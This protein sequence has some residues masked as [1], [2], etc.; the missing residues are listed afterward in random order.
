MKNEFL[1]TI[2]QGLLKGTEEEGVKTFY[3]IPYGT[4]SGHQV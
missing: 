1:A 3:R 2:S 4:Y